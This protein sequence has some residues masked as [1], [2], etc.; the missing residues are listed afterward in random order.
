MANLYAITGTDP[1]DFQNDRSLMVSASDPQ[2]A[3]DFWRQYYWEDPA[4]NPFQDTVTTVEPEGGEFMR[5]YRIKHDPFHEGALAWS[6]NQ[7]D[8][9][10]FIL[11]RK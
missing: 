10:A 8:L 11:E 6:G 9:E 5:I 7:A 4:D 3:A 2:R 1:E